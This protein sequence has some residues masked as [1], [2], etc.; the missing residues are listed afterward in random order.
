MVS[1]MRP[2]FLPLGRLISFTLFQGVLPLSVS[3]SL[4]SFACFSRIIKCLF[5]SG[6]SDVSWEIL[7]IL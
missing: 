6:F 5:L 2:P 4:P 7:G 3:T 1:N